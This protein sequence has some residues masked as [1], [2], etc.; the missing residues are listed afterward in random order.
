MINLFFQHQGTPGFPQL[1]HGV[2]T[3]KRTECAEA[4]HDE[5]T[6]S[7]RKFSDERTCF[8]RQGAQVVFSAEMFLKLELAG[9]LEIAMAVQR[10][11]SGGRKSKGS[12]P[13]SV[14]WHMDLATRMP[15]GRSRKPVEEGKASGLGCLFQV[16]A[17][18]A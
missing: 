1:Q 8:D 11:L 15:C 13:A 9:V 16:H 3:A 18:L 12:L 2:P 10:E 7:F 6:P 4:V 14:R 5:A 17:Q